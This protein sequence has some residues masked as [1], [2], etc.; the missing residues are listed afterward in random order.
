MFL[1]A[2]CCGVIYTPTVGQ[3]T[4]WV[5]QGMP[6]GT[7][8]ENASEFLKGKGFDVRETRSPSNRRVLIADKRAGTCVNSKN[9]YVVV[10]SDVDEKGNI[11]STEVTHET[12]SGS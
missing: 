11:L 8:A 3:V 9:D 5:A 2:G 4:D 6:P 1:G 12:R 10:R 7:S